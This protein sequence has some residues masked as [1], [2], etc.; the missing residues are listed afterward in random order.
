[1]NDKFNITTDAGETSLYSKEKVEEAELNSGQMMEIAEGLVK[2]RE[3]WKS[4]G[5]NIA[6][7]TCAES[8]DLDK[9]GIEHNR[10]LTAG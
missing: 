5:W 2:I 4:E 6:L 3:Q 7:A 1:M 10:Y 9:Y 8:I